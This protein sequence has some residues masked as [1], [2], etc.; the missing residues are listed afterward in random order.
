VGARRIDAGGQK[1]AEITRNSAKNTDFSLKN[2]EK[3]S[4]K[5][6]NCN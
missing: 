6:R 1:T 4:K 5:H 2:T 3:C